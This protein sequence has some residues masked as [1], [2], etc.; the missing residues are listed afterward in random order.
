MQFTSSHYP[1]LINSNYP[2]D[3]TD[4]VLISPNIKDLASFKRS[5]YI[6]IDT[7]L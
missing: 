1:S 3:G 7:L 4:V 2:V 6:V 5:A